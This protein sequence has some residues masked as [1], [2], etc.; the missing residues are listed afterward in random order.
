MI[1]KGIFVLY[2]FI[3]NLLELFGSP[4]NGRVGSRVDY[5]KKERLDPES[6]VESPD[7]KNIDPK[8][9]KD[10]LFIIYVHKCKKTP[11]FTIIII[12]I[13]LETRASD[14]G[15]TGLGGS[16]LRDSHSSIITVPPKILY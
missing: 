13:R 5:Q 2:N 6:R 14:R 15:E 16:V 3:I 9:E 1:V 11:L 10:L 4:I 8:I 7:P 12:N